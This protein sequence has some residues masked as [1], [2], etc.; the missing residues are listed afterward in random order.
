MDQD[1]NCKKKKKN[2]DNSE[3][4]QLMYGFG[5]VKFPLDETERLLDEY[6]L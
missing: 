3:L 1:E 4:K 2:K 5:D 6:I